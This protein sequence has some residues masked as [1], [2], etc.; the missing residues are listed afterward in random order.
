MDPLTLFAVTVSVAS[1]TTLFIYIF[2]KYGTREVSFEEAI[3]EQ[4][5]RSQELLGRKQKSNYNKE[6]RN[7]EVEKHYGKKAGTKKQQQRKKIGTTNNAQ[8][9]LRATTAQ[10][11]EI[12]EE[13]RVEPQEETNTHGHHHVEILPEPVVIVSWIFEPYLSHFLDF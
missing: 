13:I 8:V 3:A 9:D 5:E 10:Q 11:E 12:R 2:S 6:H 7:K 4:K 1:V